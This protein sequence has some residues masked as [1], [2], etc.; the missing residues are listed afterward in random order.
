MNK[1]IHFITNEGKTV[2]N[3]QENDFDFLSILH[4]VY[5]KLG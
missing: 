1:E 3:E 2:K 4:I 5:K